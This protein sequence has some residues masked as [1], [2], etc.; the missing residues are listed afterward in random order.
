MIIYDDTYKRYFSTNADTSP[1]P[2]EEKNGSSQK[3]KMYLL[4]LK[5]QLQQALLTTFAKL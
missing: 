1:F 4:R 3:H 2:L 5:L